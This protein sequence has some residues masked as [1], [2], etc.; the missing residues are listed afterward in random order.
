MEMVAITTTRNNTAPVPLQGT[1]HTN[2][3]V[4]QFSPLPPPS[5]L[6]TN[7]NAPNPNLGRVFRIVGSA[8][9]TYLLHEECKRFLKLSPDLY[10]R[11]NLKRFEKNLEEIKGM[12]REIVRPLM[13]NTLLGS[14]EGV[15]YLVCTRVRDKD[16]PW[17]E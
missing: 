7:L 3:T 8:P 1:H 16:F 12:A 13:K 2:T 9:S 6:S 4:Q 11:E 14:A 5:D 10:S 17:S 15:N